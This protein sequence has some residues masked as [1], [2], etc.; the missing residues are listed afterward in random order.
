[1]IKSQPKTQETILHFWNIGICTAKEI[2]KAT[3]IPMRTIYNNIKK[4]EEVGNLD[5]K[6]GA[7]QPKKITPNIVRYIGQNIRQDS[8][9]SLHSIKTKLDIKGIECSHTTIAAHLANLG[10][11]KKLPQATL[12]LTEAHKQ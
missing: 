2:H 1:M 11:N 7:G 5:H 10:Y 9:I 8:T 12:M 4:L 6:K 3:Q